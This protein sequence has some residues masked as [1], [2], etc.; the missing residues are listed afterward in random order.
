MVRISSISSTN[1]LVPDKEGRWVSLEILATIVEISAVSHTNFF[2]I[3]SSDKPAA[4]INNQIILVTKDPAYLGFPFAEIL[5]SILLD[6]VRNRLSRLMDNFRISGNDRSLQ[7]MAKQFGDGAFSR[8]P[9]SNEDNIHVRLAGGIS[10]PPVFY[11][12]CLVS[13]A[14]ITSTGADSPVQSSNCPTA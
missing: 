3:F 12:K 11:E 4:G 10:K 7:A 8:S 6:E 9:V 2:L 5:P 13:T 1:D 14:R